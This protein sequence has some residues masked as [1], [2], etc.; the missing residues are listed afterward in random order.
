MS[1][2]RTFLG[3]SVVVSKKVTYKDVL[4][5]YITYIGSYIFDDFLVGKGT[6][7]SATKTST[8]V[9]IQP[10]WNQTGQR[11]LNSFNI[12]KSTHFGTNFKSQKKDL[13]NMFEEASH[14]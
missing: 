9:G 1:T 3:H 8:H 4:D 2:V 10:E 6:L 7:G 11:I 12:C 14:V 5:C 13:K